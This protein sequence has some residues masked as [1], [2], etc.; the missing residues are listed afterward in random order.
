MIEA[1]E[2]AFIS[3][4]AGLSILN[5][6]VQETG[7]SRQ[8]IKQVIKVGGVWRKP[9]SSDPERVRR[10]TDEVNFA[11]EVHIYYEPGLLKVPSAHLVNIHSA[12]AYEVF[13]K[14]KTL[15]M[16]EHLHCDHLSFNRALERDLPSSADIHWLSFSE[17]EFYG[18]FVCCY[19][20]AMA[21][22][23]SQLVDNKQVKLVV[24]FKASSNQA[25]A[26][27]QHVLAQNE[28]AKLTVDGL[29]CSLLID[30]K[31]FESIWQDVLPNVDMDPYHPSIAIEQLSF[32]CP[33]TG[34]AL[35]LQA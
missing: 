11:D 10:F 8:K 32:K 21:A 33:A 4:Q 27:L 5:F 2:K 17:P 29:D 19:T 28:A 7:L 25:L 22:S 15:L 1:F 35:R 6:L 3:D 31:G 34:D 13:F 20:R 16:E 9:P 26:S 23:F 18:L 12:G 14:P 30:L 24:S